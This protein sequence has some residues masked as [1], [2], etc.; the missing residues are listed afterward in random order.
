MLRVIMFLVDEWER[1]GACS[2]SENPMELLEKNTRSIEVQ[3][4]DEHVQGLGLLVGLDDRSRFVKGKTDQLVRQTEQVGVADPTR[5]VQGHVV[6]LRHGDEIVDFFQEFLGFL[7]LLFKALRKDDRQEVFPLG[8]E[9]SPD[10][11]G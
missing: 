6:V 11:G 7:R 9:G 3:C 8:T 1:G 4:S 5:H 2:F 10:G